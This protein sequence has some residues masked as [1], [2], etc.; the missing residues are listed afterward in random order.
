MRPSA[1][2]AS[3]RR[4]A[5]PPPPS[6]STAPPAPAAPIAVRRC[7]IN[8][9]HDQQRARRAGRAAARERRR[10]GGR[11]GGLQR[12]LVG[13]RAPGHRGPRLLPHAGRAVSQLLARPP[14]LERRSRRGDPQ[15]LW[16]IPLD[17]TTRR[18]AAPAGR[19]CRL[20]QLATPNS[21]CNDKTES[22][23]NLRFRLNPEIHISDNLRIMSQIDL[24]DNLVLGSTPDSYAMQP[25][26]TATRRRRTTNPTGYQPVQYNGGYAPVNYAPSRFQST[27]QGAA[28]GRRQRLDELDQREARVGRVHDARRPAPLRPHARAVGPRHG[29]QRGRRHRQRLPVDG[30]PDHVHHRHQVDRPLLRRRVGLPVDGP[31]EREP[32][33]RLRRPALQHVQPLQ[34]QRVGRLHRPPHEPRAPAPASCRAATSC[35]TAASTRVYRSQYLD[36]AAGRARRERSPTA[37]RPT[38]NGLEPRQAWAIIPDAW[39]QAL[40]R[41][42][43]FEAEAV[44]IQGQIGYLSGAQHERQQPGHDPPVRPRDAD[45]VP[46]G[47][48][49][50]RPAV[51]LRLGERRRVRQQRAA[52]ARC[53]RRRPGSRAST[54]TTARPSAI[55]TFRFHPD[56][57][58]DL[59]FWRN[60]MSRVEGAYYFRPSVDYDFLRHPDGEKFGGGAAV[61][62]SRASEFEQTPGHNRDLGVELD[63][64]LY[65][66]SKDGSL[67]DDPT[68]IGG[69]YTMLQYGV[70]FPLGGLDYLPGAVTAPASTRACRPRRPCGSSSASCSDARRTAAATRTARYTGGPPPVPNRWRHARAARPRADVPTPR[71]RCPGGEAA[72]S[73]AGRERRRRTPGPPSTPTSSGRAARRAARRRR[74][75]TARRASRARRS[76]AS[77]AATTKDDAATQGLTQSECGRADAGRHLSPPIDARPG[78]IGSRRR[79]HCSTRRCDQPTTSTD[80]HALQRGQRDNP[81]FAC[82]MPC[83]SIAAPAARRARRTPSRPD[84][85]ARISAW[86]QQG[87][88][89]N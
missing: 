78:A 34:R 71:A 11:A 12:R 36:L 2:D 33:R 59:I 88:Q 73:D 76:A 37:T 42:F 77:S 62:W 43:R 46:R 23:A 7:Q 27:T 80:E 89:D 45:R 6:T 26:T 38:N 48:R 3:R 15:Y 61:I 29:R 66:Q 69:F 44:T 10:D 18:S 4:R 28:H 9:A 82:N 14:Q 8:P 41:K 86:I 49:Q 68:K 22:G 50:A 87:A 74:A 25:A 30:R 65:Y 81:A 51:R 24:L 63:A 1:R 57:R 79:R 60:I 40:W 47:R 75:A 54:R 19:R 39:V 55:S 20:R 70:F 67:N 72:R 21:T 16:P 85:L 83:G 52:P 17:Q 35:S 84:D 31:D 64:Q 56:Y 32:V 13:P 58:I 53:S 5:P